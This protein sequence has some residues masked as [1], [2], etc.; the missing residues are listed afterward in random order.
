MLAG[1]LHG[2]MNGRPWSLESEGDVLEFRA[3][4][5]RVIAALL[6]ARRMAPRGGLARR[7]FAGQRVRVRVGVLPPVT[8]TV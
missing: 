8:W 7:L 1:R 6:R 3:Q 2:A 4:S 5:V